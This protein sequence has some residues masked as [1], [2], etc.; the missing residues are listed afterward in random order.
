MSSDLQTLFWCVMLTVGVN[1]LVSW[2]Y[3][4]LMYVA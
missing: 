1:L 2:I 4:S 3:A